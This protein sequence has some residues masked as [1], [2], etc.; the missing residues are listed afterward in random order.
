MCGTHFEPPASIAHF[1]CFSYDT[2]MVHSMFG[3]LLAAA[4]LA[5]SSARIFFLKYERVDTLAV[6]VPVSLAVIV[7]QILSWNV[8]CISAALFVLA[9]IALFTNVRALARF[10]SKLYVDH[11]SFAFI[12]LSVCIFIASLALA[13][14]IVRYAPVSIDPAAFGV[15]ETKTRLTGSFASG[16]REA[17]YF[18]KTDAML[19]VY[20]PTGEKK[21]SPVVIVGSDKR[22][23]AAS[24]RPYMLLL[25]AQGYTVLACDFYAADGRWFNSFADL[26]IFRKYSMIAS[27]LLQTERFSRQ[28]DFYAF[29]MIREFGAMRDIAIQKF[30]SGVELFLACDGMA[31]AA[32]VDFIRQANGRITGALALDSVPEYRTPGFGCVEQTDPLLAFFFG[33]DRDA[34]LRVPRSLVS[35]TVRRIRF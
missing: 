29:G 33:A 16:F 2:P 15:T 28:K 19:Y 34:S 6:L 23:D 27:Y 4:L 17:N 35:E 14:V 21:S 32:A 25:A 1:I 31:D 24:Y 9:V 26:R 11:Y 18:E 8:D 30:G 5:V 10:A 7:L 20:E 22:A 3:D 13:G 12:V